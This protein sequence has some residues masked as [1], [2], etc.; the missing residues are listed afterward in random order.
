M[1]KRNRKRDQK[2][3]TP[4]ARSH[5]IGFTLIEML[6]SVTLVLIMMVLF[7]EVFQM[8]G[9]SIGKMRGLAENDQRSRTLQTIIKADLDKRT[10]RWVFPFA[11][12]ENIGA[13][14]SNIA[15][16]SGYF[17]ISEN[18]PNNDLDDVLQFTVMSTITIRNSDLNPYV[19]QALNLGNFTFPNQPDADDAQLNP[20]NTGA[21]TVAEVVYFV[22]HGNLY[23]R[24]LLIREPL[25]IAGTNPQPTD[26][27]IQTP[28][29]NNVFNP[30]ASPTPAIQ[31]SSGGPFWNDFDYSAYLT[32]SNANGWYTGAAFTGSNSLDNS[33]SGNLA[34]A[35]PALRFGFSPTQIPNV[36]AG[37]PKEFRVEATSSATATADLADFIGRF[38]LLECSDSRFVYPQSLSNYSNVPTASSSTWTLDSND[39]SVNEFNNGTRRGEDL[40]LSNVHAF[41]VQVWDELAQSFVNIGDPTLVQASSDF[42]MGSRYGSSNGTLPQSYGPRLFEN[43]ANGAVNAVF[44]TWHPLLNF[45]TNNDPSPS[46]NVTTGQNI[47]DDPP[48]RPLLLKA[49]SVTGNASDIQAWQP[50]TQYAA[51]AIVFPSGPPGT[52]QASPPYPANTPR[53]LPYGQPFF[54]R[55]VQAGISASTTNAPVPPNTSPTLPLHPAGPTDY[56]LEPAWPPV[57]GLTVIDNGTSYGVIWQAVDNR[58]PLKAIRLQIRFLDTSSQQMRQLT[59]IHSLVD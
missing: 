21:S 1:L 12:N 41:D 23:R 9:G 5:R 36:I 26:G 58:K 10:F 13:A 37:R 11:A 6:V 45:D 2:R 59:I 56:L 44:D 39:G 42:A 3:S 15:N 8:A 54:Y 46:P 52:Y 47:Y 49:A 29:A 16:R 34:I 57:D 18:N 51:G 22:R 50:A 35:N 31:Y 43:A 4:L 33:Q 53:K 17:Y 28:T 38:T 48:F 30:H 19:G 20:N 25:A 27:T 55:C 14:G 7:A 32:Y 40:L 24:Q